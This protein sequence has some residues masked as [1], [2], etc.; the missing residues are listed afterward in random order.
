[1]GNLR[2]TAGEFTPDSLIADTSFPIQTGSVKIKRDQKLTRGTVI[3]K[4][5]GHDYCIGVN[6]DN[7]TVPPHAILADDIDTSGLSV[8]TT[9]AV[10]YLSGPFNRKALKFATGSAEEGSKY[11]EEALREKGIYL[12]SVL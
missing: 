11:H 4:E 3:G 8:D 9:V 2:S 5:G 10:V 7:A 12:K 1:M 6:H